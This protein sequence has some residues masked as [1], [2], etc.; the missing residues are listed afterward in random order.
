M[1]RRNFFSKMMALPAG[2]WMSNFDTFCESSSAVNQVKITAIKVIQLDFEHDGCLLKIET[3]A[4]LVGYGETGVT[5]RVARAFLQDRNRLIGAD[6]LSIRTHFHNM[7]TPVHPLVAP[8]ALISGIDIALWDLAGKILGQPVYKLLGGPF[9]DGCP[10]YSHGSYL[11]DMLDPASCRSWADYI[12]QHT[13]GFTS[14]KLGPP[15]R[16]QMPYHPTITTAEL[17]LLSQGFS[18][19]RQAVGE[20]VELGLHL[21]NELDSYSAIAMANTC[22]PFNIVYIEDPINVPFSD[23]WVKLKQGTE[24]PVMTGEKLLTLLDFKPF[25]D[26][27]VVDII[28]P[29]ISFAGGFTGCMKIADYAAMSRTPVAL[30]N[31]GTLIRTYASA[32]LSMAIQNFYKSESSL[33]EPGRGQVTEQMTP[34]E[35]PVIKNGILQVPDRP[36]LGLLLDDDFLKKHLIKDEPWWG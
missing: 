24:V 13:E 27:K 9:R 26:E 30:H 34:A 14:F 5:S 25:L 18:N 10:M 1:N 33:G 20:S 7:T 29:D 2:L 22:K 28:H 4:G 12:K 23:G 35:P 32:H 8:M 6:P 36:G 16:V 11:K 21:H 17:K 15:F 19:L 3:D 31:V